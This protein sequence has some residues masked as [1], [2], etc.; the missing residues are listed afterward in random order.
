MLSRHA[1]VGWQHYGERCMPA[2]AVPAVRHMRR[3]YMYTAAVRRT[4][5]PPAHR[6]HAA[7]QA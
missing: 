6:A 5:Q 1:L 2:S 3:C 7:C 4:A